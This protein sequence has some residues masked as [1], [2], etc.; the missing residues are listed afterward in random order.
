MD[1]AAVNTRIHGMQ[2]SAGT[3]HGVIQA[4]HKVFNWLIRFM[5][6]EWE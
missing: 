5:D 4:R 3:D 1:W 6:A 2:G